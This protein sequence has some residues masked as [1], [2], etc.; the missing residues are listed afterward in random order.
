MFI[1]E[2]LPRRWRR[3]RFVVIVVRIVFVV[4]HP[5]PSRPSSVHTIV[6]V[7]KTAF[8]SHT[9]MHDA[10]TFVSNPLGTRMCVYVRA[11][12]ECTKKVAKRRWLP[13]LPLLRPLLL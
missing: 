3:R 7:I 12:E 11:R 4:V 6:V 9:T 5:S 1:T 8:A 13:L 2:L 10:C